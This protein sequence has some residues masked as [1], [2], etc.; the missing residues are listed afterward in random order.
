MGLNIDHAANIL[1]VVTFLFGQLTNAFWTMIAFVGGNVVLGRFRKERLPWREYLSGE[2]KKLIIYLVFVMIANR[3]DELAVGP[4]YGWNGS[5]QLLVSL[6]LIAKELK[7]AFELFDE[8]GVEVPFVLQ[9]RTD[10][11][12]NGDNPN[13]SM[14][15]DPHTIDAKIN[16]LQQKLDRLKEQQWHSRMPDAA[17]ESMLAP[18][19]PEWDF[20]LPDRP[21]L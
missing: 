20:N 19:D 17:D 9:K 3:I 13:G 8:L 1:L 7:T 16:E 4:L 2:F 5:T 21:G 11:M 12:Y 10:Q 14:H 15:I 6:G 18:H